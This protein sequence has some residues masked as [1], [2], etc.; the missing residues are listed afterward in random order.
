MFFK[1]DKS[2]IGE[3]EIPV[4]RRNTFLFDVYHKKEIHIEVHLIKVHFFI[5]GKTDCF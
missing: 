1:E 5:F 2:E 3:A 4:S